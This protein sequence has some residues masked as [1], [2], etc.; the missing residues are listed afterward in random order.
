VTPLR[1]LTS[2][3]ILITGIA[4]GGRFARAQA[5]PQVPPGPAAAQNL[6]STARATSDN[7]VSAA[8]RRTL[9]EVRYENVPL[10]RVLDDLSLRLGTNTV[11]EST[12]LGDAGVNLQ[13]PVTLLLRSMPA[14]QVLRLALE[15]AVADAPLLDAVVDDGVL[16]ISTAR[17]LGWP[18]L[19]LHDAHRLL[20][21]GPGKAPLPAEMRTALQQRLVKVI[22]QSIAPDSWDDAGGKGAITCHGDAFLVNNS[23]KVQQQVAA[24]L[25][26]LASTKC[27]TAAWLE[28]GWDNEDATNRP[29]WAALQRVIPQVSYQQVT[30]ARFAQDLRR[31]LGINVHVYAHALAKAGADAGRCA[32]LNLSNITVERLLREILSQVATPDL[33]LGWDIRNGVLLIGPSA[34][35]Q[36]IMLVRVYGIG[37]LSSNNE[38]RNWL[39]AFIKR[40]IEPD[41]WDEAGGQG[42]LTYFRG[43]FVVYQAPCVHRALEHLLTELR[44]HAAEVRAAP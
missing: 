41:S 40:T 28:P 3:L 20:A 30:L 10:R 29:V 15:E 34:Y 16:R 26:S 38:S 27:G 6:A 19:Q 17:S 31:G 22:D 36:R 25:E 12:N 39:V 33:R 1:L 2:A 4:P 43:L 7:D 11:V 9:P 44:Q 32:T 21:V 24:L 35:L 14:E 5:A 8:L 13:T 37:D 18:V 23:L 42:T